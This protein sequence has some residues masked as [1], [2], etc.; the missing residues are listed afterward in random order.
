MRDRVTRF[1]STPSFLRSVG[2]LS[3]GT[4]IGHVI[5]AGALPVLTRLYEPEAFTVLAAY[6]AAMALVVAI[7]PLRWEIAIPLPDD[8][9]DAGALAA[10]AGLAT[11]AGCLMVALILALSPNLAVGIFGET[12][13]DALAWLL[14]VG[15]LAAATYSILQ[16]WAT[17]KKRFGTVAMTHATRA[18]SGTATQVGLGAISGSPIGLVV[19][20]AIYSAVGVGSL[21]R[22]LWTRDRDLLRDF[23]PRLSV[24]RRYWRFPAFSL[25][26][27]LLNKAGSE[28]PILLIA[29][30]GHPG[31]AGFLL[32]ASRV[33][34]VPMTLIGRSVSQVFLSEAGDHARA[35]RL[36]VVTRTATRNLLLVAIP[37]L[38][39]IGALAPIV[40]PLVL[41]EGW[42]DAGTVLLMLTPWY[43][44]QLATSPVS[45]VL[46]AS[47]RLRLAA[48]LQFVGAT[49]RIGSVLIAALI[50]F[51]SLIGAFAVS[52]AGYYA[53]Y[54]AV[55]LVTVSRLSDN[56]LSER[57]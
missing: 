43:I 50:P 15:A 52:S 14:P 4:L 18:A 6:T 44:L 21:I 31:E 47:G 38:G 55:V 16:Y 45:S 7:V 25:P 17:R 36:G 11:I 1:L 23:R 32:V 9:R 37:L 5:T 53:L 30:L 56:P 20:H 42:A 26:E 39:S 12:Y 22:S 40:F 57:H 3:S 27:T 28:V 51:G 34:G 19:G 29:A 10:L 2:V 54:L 46:H 24:A 33:M 35:G 41:G 8:D 13:A 49:M 48:S